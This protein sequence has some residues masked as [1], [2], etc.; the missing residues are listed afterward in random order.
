MT[1]NTAMGKLGVASPNY[2]ANLRAGSPSPYFRAFDAWTQSGNV[3]SRS[4]PYTTMKTVNDDDLEWFRTSPNNL[5]LL[6]VVGDVDGLEVQFVVAE[7]DYEDDV[8]T[9][10]PNGTI[11]EEVDG[12]PLTRQ[13]KWSEWKDA[14]HSHDLIDGDYYVPS[15]SFGTLPKLSEWAPFAMTGSVPFALQKPA[16]EEPSP[17]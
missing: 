11:T 6:A 9:G 17:E 15:N 8:P 14:N 12:E 16:V 13:R 4:K 1:R 3:L 2:L 7:D 10:F 5:L